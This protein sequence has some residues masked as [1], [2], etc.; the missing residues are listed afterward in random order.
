MKTK[1]DLLIFHISSRNFAVDVREIKEIL[2]MASLFTPSGLPSFM[3]VF[4]NVEGNMIPVLS[5]SN[6]F[7]STAAPKELYTKIIILEQKDGDFGIITE[8]ILGIS[9]IPDDMLLPLREE[10]TFNGC[11]RAV[12]EK[13]NEKINLLSPHH[14]LLEEEKKRMEEFKKIAET[15]LDNLSPKPPPKPQRKIKAKQ[16]T[17]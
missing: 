6:L 16:K 4:L 15:R 12:F 9:T 13:N 5:L 8:S 14:I 1:I 3:E 2:H 7:F 17:E 11:I 10:K